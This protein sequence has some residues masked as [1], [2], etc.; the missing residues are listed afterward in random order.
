VDIA[1][2]LSGLIGGVLIGLA[3]VWL[4][5]TLGRISGV[6]GILSGLLLEQPAGDSAWR[7]AFLLGLF[8]GPLILILLGGGL[9]NVSGAP[10]EVIGQP[11]GD[12]GL[13]LLAGLLV[14]VGTKVGSGCTSGHGVSG[15]AQGM[16]LSA[17]VAP[18][19]LRG[20]PLAGI[21]SVMRAYA[22][23]VESWRRLGQLLVP[24]Q[25]D[26]ISSSIALDDAIEAVDDLL[27]GRI[28][29]RVVVTMA[30]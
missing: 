6:S 3:A 8:S 17:S 23:R 7:L 14:G 12:I 30:L 24:E 21:D 1:A 20:V 18:F 29:G 4:M 22:D 9:G 27:A 25:L 2:S 15:L 16:D 26:A 5:A 13:M 10:D 19:I 28:R 11:A